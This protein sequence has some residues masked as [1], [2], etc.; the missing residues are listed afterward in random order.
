MDYY[1]LSKG[2]ARKAEKVTR[3]ALPSKKK[4]IS[5]EKTALLEG[6]S[7]GYL[8]INL[9]PDILYNLT[10]EEIE[11]QNTFSLEELK[12]INEWSNDKG[13]SNIFHLNHNE[14]GKWRPKDSVQLL[15]VANEMEIT[16]CSWQFGNCKYF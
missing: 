14:N 2:K 5:S 1:H 7:P 15:G 10:P 6:L 3:K 9:E 11:S 12:L 13:L 8:R 4:F 16:N